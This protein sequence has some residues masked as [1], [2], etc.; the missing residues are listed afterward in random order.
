MCFLRDSKVRLSHFRLNT[1]MH[2]LCN[3]S[4]VHVEFTHTANYSYRAWIL[5]ACGGSLFQASLTVVK[6]S[7]GYNSCSF[8]VKI[9]W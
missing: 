4:A 2:I 5:S 6:I 9:D 3:Y 7:Q 1:H 8:G